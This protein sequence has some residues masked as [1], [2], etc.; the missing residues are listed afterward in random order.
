MNFDAALKITANVVGEN[1]IRKLGNSMQGLEGKIKNAG[2]ASKAANIKANTGRRVNFMTC[3][4]WV[5]NHCGEMSLQF[6]IQL[7]L[8][9]A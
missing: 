1:N 3:L 9:R 4:H 8:E 6:T 2:L 7:I 5:K